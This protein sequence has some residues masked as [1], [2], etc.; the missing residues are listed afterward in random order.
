MSTTPV[1][2]RFQ[3]A[4]ESKRGK[5]SRVGRL[6]RSPVTK[7]LERAAQGGGT[8]L[9]QWWWLAASSS[10]LTCCF[11]EEEEGEKE[12]KKEGSAGPRSWAM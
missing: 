10:S 11:R 8:E 4:Q 9:R 1:A 2:G 5:I 6:P 12:R 3:A 7:T